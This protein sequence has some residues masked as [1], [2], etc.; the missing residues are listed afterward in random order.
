MARRRAQPGIPW[1]VAVPA[2]VLCC[3]VWMPIWVCFKTTACCRDCQ[4]AASRKCSDVRRARQRT[5]FERLVWESKLPPSQP[6]IRDDAQPVTLAS[7][8]SFLHLPLEIRSYIYELALGGPAIVQPKFKASMRGSRPTTWQL[9]QHIRDDEELPSSA[10]CRIITTGGSGLSQ[11]IT[12]RDHS[13]RAGYLIPAMIYDG[14]RLDTTQGYILRVMGQPVAPH[15]RAMLTCRKVYDDVLHRLYADSTISLFG[16]EMVHYFTRNASPEGLRRVRYVHVAL[17]I[18][19]KQWET[20]KSKSAVET[21]LCSISETFT[22]LREL[23]VEIVLMWSQ[24]NKPHQFWTWLKDELS[25]HSRGLDKF[26]MK[27]AVYRS[28]QPRRDTDVPR[29]ERL[30][31]WDENEYSALK[32][33]VTSPVAIT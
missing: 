6:I 15:I 17:V 16:A 20:A 1:W 18:A 4:R 3:P 10:L 30:K 25:R 23:D 11:I 24:P 9:A 31:G 5:K 32:A 33:A 7:K 28:G 14:S 8:T 21:A 22:G 29:F 26:V 27:I 19:S 13:C 12:I 2:F